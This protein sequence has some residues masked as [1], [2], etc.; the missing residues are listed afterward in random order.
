MPVATAASPSIATLGALLLLLAAAALFYLAGQQQARRSFRHWGL[1]CLVAATGLATIGFARLA[2]VGG[3][4]VML[5]L[6]D[7]IVGASFVLQAQ[8]MAPSSR[9]GNRLVRTAIAFNVAHLL[10]VTQFLWLDPDPTLRPVATQLVGAA[11]L[12][13]GAVMVWRPQRRESA[14]F[15]LLACGTWVAM[16]ALL[17]AHASLGLWHEASPGAELSE[18]LATL[19]LL[20]FVLLP[21]AD[22]VHSYRHL[23]EQLSRSALL[24]PLTQLHNRRGLVEAWGVLEARARRGDE[25]WHVGVILLDIDGFRALNEVH[26]QATGDAILQLAAEAMRQTARRYDIVCRFGGDEFC[27][28]LPGVTIR[29]CQVITERVRLK[30]HQM[31]RERTGIETSLSAGVTV[32]DAGTTSVEKATDVADHMLYAAKREGRDRSRIDPDAVRVI[33]G[34]KPLQQ[35]GKQDEF[36]F[37]LV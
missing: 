12:A 23:T 13:L 35:T 29:Q 8:A 37:P 28:L 27:M 22:I 17:L 3:H 16:A 25:G 32:T 20:A 31:V 24:D 1:G 10:A 21:M 14:A 2:G 11:G 36:G 19:G 34:L 6:A 9:A 15:N 5:A 33:S 30:F 18:L 26:G 7:L 4:P